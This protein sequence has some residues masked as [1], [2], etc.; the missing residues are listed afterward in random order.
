MES[1]GWSTDILP[2]AYLELVEA[3]IAAIDG[4]KKLPELLPKYEFLN[5]Q[6]KSLG[7]NSYEFTGK[8]N[9][10]GNTV[11]V[12]ELPPDLSLEKFKARLNKMEDEDLIQTYIDR[13]T[14]N[15]HVEIRFKRGTLQGSPASIEIVDGKKVKHPAILPWTESAVIE[16]LKLRSRA[17]ERIVVLDWSGT[18]IKQYKDPE[19][20]IR[21]FVEWRLG[22]YTIRFEKLLSDTITQLN[23]NLA[24]KMCYDKGLPSFLPKAQNRLEIIDKISI[25]TDKLTLTDE[26]RDRIA[27]LPSY[28]W[29]KDSYDDI[30]AKI[31][32][33]QNTIIEYKDILAD[34]A[35]LRAIYR[36]EVVTLK[37]LQVTKR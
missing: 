35:K 7:N 34:P 20:L 8:V 21:A 22:F 5:C 12:S 33:L 9:I 32:S 26:Q 4:K 6:V 37:K 13:S 31:A 14:K 3:T 2:R 16:F 1:V 23:W 28:R 27:S 17:T 30:I 19:T 18:N 25:I 24:V 29:A 15:I 36:Q 11:I 10:D